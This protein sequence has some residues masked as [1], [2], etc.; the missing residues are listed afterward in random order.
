MQLNATTQV[1]RN[2]V[3]MRL[4]NA[5]FFGD[6]QNPSFITKRFYSMF[7]DDFDLINV[8]YEGSLF[9]NRYHVGA[10][11]QIRGIGMSVT[12]STS[13]FG[14]AGKL[15]GLSRFPIDSL[16]DVDQGRNGAVG[17][18]HET[19]HQWLAF[20]EG[21]FAGS[22]PHWP[23]SDL[24]PGIMGFSDPTNGQGLGIPGDLIPEG[25]D[26]RIQNR[27]GIPA[28]TFKDLELYLMG[29][30]PAVA[31]GAA[32][33]LAGS[34]ADREAQLGRAVGTGGYGDHTADRRNKWRSGAGFDGA[35]RRRFGWRRFT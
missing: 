7:P 15:L 25:S 24:A 10:K 13:T 16:F 20:L 26:F 4:T 11:N 33:C 1:S 9:Q 34:D 17:W 28:Q 29:F 14:S 8:V 21:P 19:G 30:I 3:N 2:L 18:L 32:F 31:G 5:E 22:R 27:N 6:F 23:F 35:R 12:D